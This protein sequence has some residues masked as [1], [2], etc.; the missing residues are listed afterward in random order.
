[1]ATIIDALVVSLGLDPSEF[2]K[3][4]KKAVD[5]LKKLEQT[6]EKST[7][8]LQEQ[9]K[10]GGASFAKFRNEVIGLTAAILGTSAIKSFADRITV[11][12]SAL[13]FMAKNIG[14]STE[15]LSAWT[16]AAEK[17][18]GT[19]EGIVGSFKGLTERIQQFTLTGEGGES[20]KYFSALGI[21]LADTTGNMRSMNDIMLDVADSLSKMAAPKAIAWGKG[22]GFDEG[23]INVLMQGRT[24]VQNLLDEQRKIAVVTKEDTKAAFERDVAWKKVSDRLENLGRNILTD[25]SPVI[26]KLGNDFS[27]WIK[28]IDVI[29][30]EDFFNKFIQASK[31]GID[32]VGGLTN[33]IELFFGLWIGSKALGI[34]SFLG[35]VSGALTGLLGLF[36]KLT[37]VGA[38]FLGGWKIG[39]EINKHLSEDTKDTIGKFVYDSIESLKGLGEKTKGVFSNLAE[40]AFGKLISRGE[41]EYTSVHTK[42]GAAKRNLEEMTINQVMEAQE[43]GEF[44]AAGRYQVIGSTMK[45]A[46]K[47]M[48]LTGGE[49]FN[50]ETQDKIF[51]EYLVKHK[52]KAIADYIS[53]RSND[54]Q[55]ALKAVSMEWASATNPETGKSYYEGIS[56]NKATISLS[57]MTAALNA[58]R[59]KNIQNNTANTNNTSSTDVNVGQVSIYTQSTDAPGIAR[60]INSALQ[61][62]TFASQA[63][64]GLF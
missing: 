8:N 54:L 10:K 56:G 64:V 44:G 43:K 52:R 30:I 42:K 23:T 7:K 37:G 35:N 22:M 51:S 29:K 24:A 13:G 2:D 17:A 49:K 34:L 53:G 1:M 28:K 32:I 50:K 40:S 9:A 33:A 11:S 60:D 31:S 55:A 41:G 20:F 61:S 12:D 27:E 39:E 26:I 62:Y 18:G 57:E 16:K 25:L 38:A 4:Q 48:G 46:V 14:M 63:N 5:S 19:A 6:S 58:E 21:A 59:M 3:G 15:D 45:E 36:G 47:T